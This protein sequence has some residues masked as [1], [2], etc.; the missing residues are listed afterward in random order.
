M[1]RRGDYWPLAFT[2]FQEFGDTT[3]LL[4][5]R[6]FG[7]VSFNLQTSHQMRIVVHMTG[8]P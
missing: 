8:A 5:D 7:D 6:P 2:Y 4:K 1:F 3:M